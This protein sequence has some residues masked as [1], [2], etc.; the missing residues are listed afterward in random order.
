MS[1]FKFTI[2]NRADDK[3]NWHAKENSPDG[4]ITALI[5]RGHP[6]GSKDGSGI[7]AGIFKP[8]T[9]LEQ[10]NLEVA[11]GVVLDIDGKFKKVGD[12]IPP[13]ARLTDDGKHYLEAIQPDW[14]VGKLPFRGVAHSSF[15][16]SPQHPKFRVILP[17]AAPVTL[18][19]F[20]RLW[21]WLYE[22]TERKIDAA[23]KNPDRMFFL[24]R[25]TAEAKE[26][27]WPWIR[28]M[29]GP[30]LDYAMVPEDFQIPQEYRYE[31]ERPKKKQGAHSAAPSS[32]YRHTDAF[33]L[34]EVLTD[35]PIYAWAMDNPSDVSRETWRGLATNI[36]A[37]V[38]EDETAH[39]AGSKAFHELSEVDDV[40]YAYGPTEK[41]WRDAL[42]SAAHPGPMSYATLKLNGAPSDID[43]GDCRAPIAH[44]RKLLSSRRS[45]RVPPPPTPKE[46]PSAGATASST[47]ASAATSTGATTGS[48]SEPAPSAG[49]DTPDDPTDLDITRFS[50][51]DF[52]FDMQRNGWLMKCPDKDTGKY[53]WDLETVY[54]DEALNKFLIC[55]GLPKRAL[56]DWKSQIKHIRYRKPIYTSQDEI[57][58]E[59]TVRIFNTYRPSPLIPSPAP[60]SVWE[61]IRDLFL[62]LVGNDPKAY[63]YVLD[64]I[65]LPL[66]RI[67]KRLDPLV[68]PY[69][70]GTAL[71]FRGDPGAGKGTA[72]NIISLMYGLHNRVVLGQDDLDGKFHTNLIDKLFVV[73]NEVMSSSNRSIQTANKLKSWVTDTEIPCEAKY[74]DARMV[75][76]NFN[77]VFTSNDER[78]VL[79]DRN[80]RRYSVFQSTA[81]NKKVI[82]PII[83]DTL[84][85]KTMVA[86]FYDH[87]LQRTTNI[88]Y[89]QI[90]ETE[91]RVQ[92]QNFSASTSER[93]AD[94]IFEDGF[95]SVSS[96]WV[97][98]APHGQIRE[99]MTAYHGELYVLVD[100]V[101][102]VYK[103]FCS[104]LGAFPQGKMALV[105]SLRQRFPA[106][107]PD[108]RIRV[109]GIQKRAWSGLPADSPHADVIPIAVAQVPKAVAVNAPTPVVV[110]G[111]NPA[112]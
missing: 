64:W 15:T 60:L 94:A 3:D 97:D 12:T 10:K 42:K 50:T 27:G 68:Y 40:R 92:V 36:A 38:L 6:A 55:M 84:G 67:R 106:S 17:L 69:K 18:L 74:G 20:T 45:P 54:K 78:P 108:M 34:L 19:E 9:R 30:L 5:Q 66:Q 80:D 53:D 49:S 98:A 33:Q 112:I 96:G 59:G 101:M 107:V 89:G 71:V 26:L 65:A 79:V 103:H 57:V 62:H 104:T 105:R 8:G 35:L 43:E 83:D 75:P 44:A 7:V 72:T 110:E 95:L 21:F 46:P 16:H 23:C 37:A 52:L 14:L 4:F 82:Q 1:Q 47:S 111:D 24:P 58:T 61:P 11:T 41:T 91:A 70:M 56:D 99:A 22:K 87:L 90:Y 39:E 28:E 81:V 109:G 13:G 25:C 31:I 2:T 100:T 88:S 63:E 73:C 29:Y 48:S 76:N 85:P 86:A 93:F 51:D 102:A 32:K 77:I